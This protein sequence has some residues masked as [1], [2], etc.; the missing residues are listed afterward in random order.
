[1]NHRRFVALFAA[2]W[3]ATAPARPHAAMTEPDVPPKLEVRVGHRLYLIGHAIGTQN[4]V[5]LPK[6]TA[7]AWTP[8]GPQATLFADDG[9]Q[10]TTHFLSTN[11]VDGVARATWQHSRDTSSVWAA[12]IETSD[13]PAYVEPG[14]VP[15]LLLEV[16]GTSAGPNAGERL[17]STTYIQR[18]HTSGGIAPETGCT[19]AGHVG[20]KALVPYTTDYYFYKARGRAVK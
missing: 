3:L 16:K 1:M 9:S 19:E 18:V 7:F 6:G 11:P 5:C 20:A 2:A 14:A 10:L 15:W 8:F 4:Y 13:D 17:A 12:A